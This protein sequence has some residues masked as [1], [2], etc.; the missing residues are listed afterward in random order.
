MPH[1]GLYPINPDRNQP[2]NNLPD[3]PIHPQLYR[4][5]EVYEQLAQAKEALGRLQGRSV[6]IPNQGLLVNSISLQE[7]K[8]SSAIENIFTTDDELYRAFSEQNGELASEPTKEVLRYREAL[9]EGFHYLQQQGGFSLD[10]FIRV[11]R[12]IKQSTENVRP[13]FSPVYI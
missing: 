8:A 13:A 10:Y 11:F 5:V 9:W 6:A 3:L 2:W 12:E 4:T 1:S 7:A